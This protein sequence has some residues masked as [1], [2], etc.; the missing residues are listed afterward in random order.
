MLSDVILKNISYI[1]YTE[2][3]NFTSMN[4][5][6]LFFHKINK[7]NFQTKERYYIFWQNEYYCLTVLGIY[8]TLAKILAHQI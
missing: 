6:L 8:L 4:Y 1:K 5:R 2:N 3:D 7:L